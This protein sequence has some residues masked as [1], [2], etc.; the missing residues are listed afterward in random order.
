MMSHTCKRVAES[1][2]SRHPLYLPVT[3]LFY[4]VWRPRATTARCNAAC[5]HLAHRFQRN[6]PHATH[7][8]VFIPAQIT[9][10]CNT[11]TLISSTL[12]PPSH[13]SLCTP[14]PPIITIPL[15]CNLLSVVSL[16]ARSEMLSHAR[17]MTLTRLEWVAWE[18]VVSP[19]SP[20]VSCQRMTLP[21]MSQFSKNVSC[22]ALTCRNGRHGRH[23]HGPDD[24][25]D[26]W[27][28][29]GRY[30]RYGRHGR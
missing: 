23:G 4:C 18:G 27:W 19:A 6:S 22:A 10:L 1:A 17:R 21:L 25:S 13:P 5:L 14:C 20:H 28:R 9:A 11:P 8:S 24:G 15:D 30:G 3:H 26:G 7:L 2:S 12:L 16:L 29:H